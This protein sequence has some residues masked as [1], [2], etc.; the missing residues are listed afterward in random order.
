MVKKT[1]KPATPAAAAVAPTPSK[2]E[3]PVVKAPIEDEDMD[4]QDVDAVKAE[5]SQTIREKKENAAK[6]VK[7]VK[8]MNAKLKASLERK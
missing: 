1:S 3:K 5:D 7:Q 4:I 2:K 8:K 6:M